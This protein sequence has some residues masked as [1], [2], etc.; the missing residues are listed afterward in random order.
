MPR[1][2]VGRMTRCFGARW[3]WSTSQ[4]ASCIRKQLL[5]PQLCSQA[6]SRHFPAR[7]RSKPQWS[8]SRAERSLGSGWFPGTPSTRQV[9]PH[10]CSSHPDLCSA[11]W[12]CSKGLI[13]PD[14]QAPE[15]TSCQAQGCHQWKRQC[16]QSTEPEPLK[17]SLQHCPSCGTRA[18]LQWQPRCL[19]GSAGGATSR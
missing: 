19:R 3:R 16:T 10:A 1:R 5:L 2:L 4:P 7:M 14:T 15:P 8:P 6:Y 13:V 17:P 11:A 12:G 9:C 18:Q